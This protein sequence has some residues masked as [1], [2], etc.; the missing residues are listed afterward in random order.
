MP[1]YEY[2]CAKGHRFE[3]F[4]R[5]SDKPKTRCP[6]CGAQA[7]RVISGGAGLIFKGS[8]FYLTDYGKAGGKKG[9]DSD[10]T[11]AAAGDA[12]SAKPARDSA[13]AAKSKG[14]D[15]PPSGAKSGSDS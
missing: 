12:K 10:R 2:Q 5:I 14:S 9:G 7:K 4:Q 6:E 11:E 8:G 1:T 15:S 13:A 3:A